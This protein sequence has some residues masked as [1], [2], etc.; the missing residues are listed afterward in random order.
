MRHDQPLLV[1]VGTLREI[2]EQHLD[3]L[4]I[5]L[6]SFWEQCNLLGYIIDT[7]Q[8]QAPCSRLAWKQEPKEEIECVG[9]SAIFPLPL[10]KG[11]VWIS[12]DIAVFLKTPNLHGVFGRTTMTGESV[13]KA[14]NFLSSYK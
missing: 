8:T 9:L 13:A 14:R 1:L 4:S 5:V 3:C 2:L 7:W 10:G 11:W 12:K 6:Q